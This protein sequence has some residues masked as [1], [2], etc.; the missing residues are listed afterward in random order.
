MALLWTGAFAQSNPVAL[1]VRNWREAHE[2]A[3][4]QEFMELLAIPN[5]AFDALNI[6]RNAAAV[7]KLLEQRGVQTRLLKVPGA[8]PVVYG[9]ILKP[10]AHTLM[11]QAPSC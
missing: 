2:Q 3:I 9:E 1:S 11:R 5:L 6:Q 7:Q 8:P 4:L 10:A